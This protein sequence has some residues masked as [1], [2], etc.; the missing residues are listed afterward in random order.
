MERVPFARS[1]SRQVLDPSQDFHFPPLLLHHPATKQI[2]P[3]WFLRASAL[4]P[5]DSGHM[6]TQQR[7]EWM[8]PSPCSGV[9]A[10]AAYFTANRTVAVLPSTLLSTATTLSPLLSLTPVARSLLSPASFTSTSV[11]LPP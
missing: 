4:R 3:R 6:A 11:L 9:C 5:R 2:A 10:D 1:T 8:K 7:T